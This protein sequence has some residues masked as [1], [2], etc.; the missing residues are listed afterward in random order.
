[1]KGIIFTE[2]LDMIEEKFGLETV[3]QIIEASALPSGGAYT[4]V[5]TYDHQEIVQLL[6]Q[7][8]RVAGVPVA[9]LLRNFGQHLF[10]RFVVRYP[11]MFEGVPDAFT[12]LTLIDSQI[13][14]EVRKLYS[15]AEL[16]TFAC[17]RVKPNELTMLYQSKRGMEDLAEGLIKGCALHFR[18]QLLVRREKIADGVG[19]GVR[20][21]I[22]HLG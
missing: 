1:M 2:L 16:P 7:L 17:T 20:F 12:F 13:H 3:D 8:H 19:S 22:L 14:T 5:G 4:S 18:E 11:E 15:D 10:G 6:L 9:D 21:H